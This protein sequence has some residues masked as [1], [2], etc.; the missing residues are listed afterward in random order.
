MKIGEITQIT[1]ELSDLNRVQNE[2]MECRKRRINSSYKN[3]RE[4]ILEEGW[5]KVGIFWIGVNEKVIPYEVDWVDKLETIEMTPGWTSRKGHS[6]P[7]A[8]SMLISMFPEFKGTSWD[9]IPRGRVFFKPSVEGEDGIGRYSVYISREYLNNEN[10]KSQVLS[11]F[12]LPK[13]L[14]DWYTDSHYNQHSGENAYR[15]GIKIIDPW[16]K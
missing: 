8:I 6:E 7:L 5:G 4:E 13:N 9:H 10:V 16:E 1:K 2:Q 15:S 11:K 12:N 3:L 14:T